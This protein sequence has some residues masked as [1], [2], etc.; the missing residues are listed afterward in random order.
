MSSSSSA[1]RLE[2]SP[3]SSDEGSEEGRLK[4]TVAH[5]ARS[6]ANAGRDSG[7][8]AKQRSLDGNAEGRP[9]SG[10]F[11]SFQNQ[12]TRELFQLA[13]P[14]AA[15]MLGETAIGLV[16]T[17][18]VGA[19]GAAALGGVGLATTLMYLAYSLSFGAMRGVKVRVAHAIGEG[20]RSTASHT[21]ARASSWA[22]R[23]ACS[24]SSCAVT[25]RRCS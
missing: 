9:R 16:D 25:S 24:S 2:E 15:A 11:F 17:K 22:A 6:G 10:K 23:S 12:V 21:R 20:L 4:R 3:A 14:I 8:N 1:E 18:L 13:W 5:G 7:A 19:L